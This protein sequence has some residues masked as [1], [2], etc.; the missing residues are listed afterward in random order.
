MNLHR[1]VAGF[2]IVCLLLFRYEPTWSTGDHDMSAH[3]HH[4]MDHAHDGQAATADSAAGVDHSRHQQ[5]SPNYK[6]EQSPDQDIASKDDGSMQGGSAPTDARD[7][8]AFADGYGFGPIPPPVMADREMFLGLLV[9]RL[10]SLITGDK[11]FMT[12]DFQ[13]WYGQTYDKALIRAE[14][15]I[16]DGTF[17]NARSE[18]LWAHALDANWDLH[19]GLRY[20]AGFGPDR[21]WFAAGVQG[22]APYWIYVEATAYVGEDGR[23]AFR[24]ETEYDLLLTQRLVLQPRIEANFYG[25]T[26]EARQLGHGLSDLAVGLRL[27]YEIRRELAPYIGIEWGGRLG[28]SADFLRASGNRTGEL[29]AIAGIQFWY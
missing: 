13:A 22:F 21:Q 1:K 19:L 25:K 9:D 15:D 11:A 29:R 24:I 26:D 3:D 12:Y 6:V 14:G 23:T 16:D 8:H 27:H 18:L 20:D 10:E 7:P 2:V 4:A 17:Q 28:D 5:S